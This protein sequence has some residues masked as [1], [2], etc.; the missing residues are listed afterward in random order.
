LPVAVAITSWVGYFVHDMEVGSGPIYRKWDV[1]GE[2]AALLLGVPQSGIVQAAAVIVVLS[3][4]VAGSLGLQRQGNPA[5]TFFGMSLLVAPVLVFLVADPQ[6][7]Y[8]RYFAV[9]FPFL[10]LLLSYVLCRV[11]RRSPRIGRPLSV[12]IVCL[13]VAGQSLRIYP[14]L[15]LGRGSY[16]AALTRILQQ[17]SQPVVRVGSDHDFR[18]RTVLA[19]Y[20]PRLPGGQRLRYIEQS[21]WREEPP[22]WFLT[23]SQ[24]LS[25][26]P[27]PEITLAPGLDYGFAAEYRFSGI[28]GWSWYLYRRQRALPASQNATPITA[29][30]VIANP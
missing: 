15:Q 30:A 21:R 9:C 19:F 20:V 24:D 10:Y 18:N 13:F 26:Q 3:V 28:S 7:F 6:A 23:H 25:Y 4:I 22:D 16:V 27:A 14:L 5:S 17:S 2:A 1:A 8:F 11:G 12:A 29:V